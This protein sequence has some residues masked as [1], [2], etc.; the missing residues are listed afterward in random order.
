MKP[1]FLPATAALLLTLVAASGC[2]SDSSSGPGVNESPT[3]PA[4]LVATWHLSQAGDPVCDPDTGECVQSFARSETLDLADDGTF[5]HALFFES[6]FPPCDLVVH[7][8]SRGSAEASGD[9]L[10][11]RIS[12]GETHVED[13]CGSRGGDT[14]EAGN[15]ET[16]TY[17]I[18]EGS[19]GGQELMLTDQEGTDIGPY[20]RQ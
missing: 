19:S 13:N 6:H 1:E 4:E 15:T 12:E 14:N 17:Q 7:H 10:Q 9:T 18:S 20:E 11:L 5:D 2:G 8:Q 16:F 3:L